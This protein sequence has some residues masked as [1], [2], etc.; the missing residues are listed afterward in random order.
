MMTT[1]TIEKH[2]KNEKMDM[3]NIGSHIE[4]HIGNAET[5]LNERNIEAAIEE[6]TVAVKRFN[7]D[8]NLVHKTM[9]DAIARLTTMGGRAMPP[10]PKALSLI[11]LRMTLPT[12]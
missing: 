10:H 7:E 4:R 3:E 11:K 2:S 9:N 8:H 12:S 5:Y 1:H 6:L